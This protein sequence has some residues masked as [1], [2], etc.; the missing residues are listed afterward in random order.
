MFLLA[1]ENQ[2]KRKEFEALFPG[3]IFPI[4]PNSPK[5]VEDGKTYQENALKKA[6]AYFEAF[7]VPV[8]ADD[9]GIEV[10]A[11]DGKPGLHSARFGGEAISWPERRQLLLNA[12]AS[13]SNRIALF[14]A[15]LCYY[16][17]KRTPIFAEGIVKGKILD[18]DE[19]KEGFGYDPIFYSLTLQKSYG[20]ATFQEKLQDSHRAKAAQKL[21]TLLDHR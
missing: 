4:R 3:L 8:L 14:R 10:A 9:S 13:H 5:V 18:K 21:I 20:L 15:V 16:D 12:L 6:V 1:T 19:G 11:L 7:R 2:G 17:G